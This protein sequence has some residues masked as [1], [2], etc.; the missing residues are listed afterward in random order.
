MHME[1]YDSRW[2]FCYAWGVTWV[3]CRD[4]DYDM[5]VT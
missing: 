2:G 4:E 5:E 1:S 3:M